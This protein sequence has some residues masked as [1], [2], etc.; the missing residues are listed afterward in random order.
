MYNF[1]QFTPHL[2]DI[3]DY[4]RRK[5]PKTDSRLR[6]DQRALENRQLDLA[7]SEKHRLEEKQRAARK[8]LEKQGLQYKPKYLKASVNEVTGEAIYIPDRDYW[9]ER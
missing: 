7:A 8:E 2:N 5:L 1:T 9:Q 6:P 4:L 3:N